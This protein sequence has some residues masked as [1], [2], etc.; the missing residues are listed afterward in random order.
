MKLKKE[1]ITHMDGE[2]QIM[3]DISANFSGLVRSNKTAAEIVSLLKEDTT[4][5]NIVSAM[6]DKY[7]VSEDVLKKDVHK[8]VETLRRIEAID[9]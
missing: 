2:N 8:I 9:E 1:F 6:L 3:V 4:E 5:E 7:N